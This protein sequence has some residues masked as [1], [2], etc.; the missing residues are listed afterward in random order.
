M[1]PIE[2]WLKE[3]NRSREWLATEAST[4][5]A[6]ISRIIAG[7]QWAGRKLTLRI[8]D[9][10]GLSADDILQNSRSEVA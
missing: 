7:T 8:K 6:T 10:T 2:I 1:H 3:N 9:V 4:T 5:T